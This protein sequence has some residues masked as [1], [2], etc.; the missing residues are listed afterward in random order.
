MAQWIDGEYEVGTIGFLVER[1]NPMRH[2]K[3]TA[4][5]QRPAHTNQ[6]HQ[7]RLH[8]WCGAWNDTNTYAEGVW[9][10]T[11]GTKNGRAQ[12]TR[13]DDYA[14]LEAYLEGVGYPELLLQALQIGRA[15]V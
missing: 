4:L 12:I 5:H 8:G 11:R 7:P 10:V 13:V 9:R 6:S 15:H 2:T 1:S 3:T 14:L